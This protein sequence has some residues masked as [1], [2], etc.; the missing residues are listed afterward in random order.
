MSSI[1]YSADN[2]NAHGV[3]NVA[4]VICSGA[5][6]QLNGLCLLTQCLQ[7]FAVRRTTCSVAFAGLLSLQREK[8]VAYGLTLVWSLIA[9]CA[10]HKHVQ[11]VML[12]SVSGIV[13][14]CI[15]S[16]AAMVQKQR[17]RRYSPMHDGLGEAL[18]G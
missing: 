4:T 10:K 6:F 13:L 16:A 1:C 3:R 11:S 9:V 5:S 12:V 18:Q 17:Q 2:C 8:D 14:L 15:A 7:L